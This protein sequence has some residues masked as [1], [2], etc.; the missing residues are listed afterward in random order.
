MQ[1]TASKATKKLSNKAF[2]ATFNAISNARTMKGLKLNKENLKVI[3]ERLTPEQQEQVAEVLAEPVV[4]SALG[5]GASIAGGWPSSVLQAAEGDKDIC[6]SPSRVSR[7]AEAAFA[8]VSKEVPIFRQPS[9]HGP[10]SLLYDRFLK[11]GLDLSPRRPGEPSNIGE[12]AAFM[13]KRLNVAA[14]MERAEIIASKQQGSATYSSMY[15]PNIP[16]IRRSSKVLQAL[17]TRDSTRSSLTEVKYIDLSSFSTGTCVPSGEEFLR[18]ILQKVVRA[19]TE[20]DSTTAANK[21]F[22]ACS[23]LQTVDE[24][25]AE[26]FSFDGVNFFYTAAQLPFPRTSLERWRTSY[27]VEAVLVSRIVSRIERLGCASRTADLAKVFINAV[28]FVSYG[29]ISQWSWDYVR[30]HS[31]SLKRDGDCNTSNEIKRLFRR[32]QTKVDAS[33]NILSAMSASTHMDD[34]AKRETYVRRLDEL[35]GAVSVINDDLRTYGG[36]LRVFNV[37]P[38][39]SSDIWTTPEMAENVV[40]TYADC[41]NAEQ[42]LGGI[43]DAF[44]PHKG[45]SIFNLYEC[46]AGN[47]EAVAERRAFERY[48]AKQ[49][50]DFYFP[51]KG[52]FEQVSKRVSDVL[53]EQAKAV[54]SG[55]GSTYALRTT[56]SHS[57]STGDDLSQLF[58]A[59]EPSLYLLIL[60]RVVGEAMSELIDKVI[61]SDVLKAAP[62]ILEVS[63]YE[64]NYYTETVLRNLLTRLDV[65]MALDHTIN[66]NDPSGYPKSLSKFSTSFRKHHR[67]RGTLEMQF[68]TR[69]PDARWTDAESTLSTFDFERSRVCLALTGAGIEGAEVYYTDGAMKDI[70][71]GSTTLSRINNSTLPG[72]A[73]KRFS[74]YALRGDIRVADDERQIRMFKIIAGA[75]NFN[76]IVLAAKTLD[77]FFDNNESKALLSEKMREGVLTREGLRG[78]QTLELLRKVR[79]LNIKVAEKRFKHLLRSGAEKPVC[80]VYAGIPGTMKRI[81]MHLN[82]VLKNPTY[83]HFTEGE[84]G[85]VFAEAIKKES[86]AVDELWRYVAEFEGVSSFDVLLEWHGG[87]PQISPPLDIMDERASYN[88]LLTKLMIEASKAKDEDVAKVFA[89]F[90]T[91]FKTLPANSNYPL[92]GVSMK[93]F[94]NLVEDLRER[95]DVRGKWA[96]KDKFDYALLKASEIGFEGLILEN[97]ALEGMEEFF[98]FANKAA[99]ASNIFASN[100]SRGVSAFTTAKNLFRNKDVIFLTNILNVLPH[101]FAFHDDTDENR[102]NEAIDA[103]REQAIRSL[104]FVCGQTARNADVAQEIGDGF[105]A[106][107]EALGWNEIN[108]AIRDD[109][110]SPECLS[111]VRSVRELLSAGVFDLLRIRNTIDER[112]EGYESSE[113]HEE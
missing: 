5:A 13:F 96:V 68:V 38:P 111:R 30:S 21:I 1:V 89:A 42:L 92:T 76:K 33:V 58:A 78:V 95:L 27:E 74:K 83:D 57:N 6:L 36:D 20:L 2:E 61:A 91:F 98:E 87:R 69:Q 55:D 22:A 65:L 26:S 79:S 4:A 72:H 19:G 62:E 63:R 43:H 56:L 110:M 67:D 60:G 66:S 94:Q 104:N 31:A 102:S 17:V 40:K 112:T 32:G 7:T 93:Y 34:E 48:G 3:L 86:I 39:N 16:P 54:R 37:L 100:I 99:L 53:V 81:S 101:E 84:I 47:V 82:Q 109:V 45:L 50:I 59:E 12:L 29:G 11:L 70:R 24:S 85:N 25:V 15:P 88:Q 10:G 97:P 113:G 52:V 41:E 77:R 80:S 49:D 35:E 64:E 73:I 14:D 107:S 44:E 106:I 9:F 28:E 71:S 103:I 75:S 8:E 46:Y 108:R 23:A 18:L 90:A 51:T 105:V